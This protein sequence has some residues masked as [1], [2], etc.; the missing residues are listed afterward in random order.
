[1]AMPENTYVTG[2]APEFMAPYEP[3]LST[4]GRIR[5]ARARQELAELLAQIEA[6]QVTNRGNLYGR[7]LGRKYGAQNTAI[8]RASADEASAGALREIQKQ[9]GRKKVAGNLADLDALNALLRMQQ[10]E[11]MGQRI[12]L[13]L[14]LPASYLTT[15]L[16]KYGENNPGSWQGGWADAM[17]LGGF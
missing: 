5:S 15:G 17:K 6:S 13:G 14:R 7:A 16:E 11:R 3:I 12:G 9:E 8:T 2:G 4:E 10:S 1:M